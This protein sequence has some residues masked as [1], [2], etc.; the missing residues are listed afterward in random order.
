MGEVIKLG[1][2]K[3]V[4]S[5]VSRVLLGVGIVVSAWAQ[6]ET[7][8]Q[9]VD[10]AGELAS[11]RVVSAKAEDGRTTAVN[12]RPIDSRVGY[13]EIERDGIVVARS[14]TWTLPASEAETSGSLLISLADAM[15]PASDQGYWEFPTW[16]ELRH[17]DAVIFRGRPL[18]LAERSGPRTGASLSWEANVP[19][20]EWRTGASLDPEWRWSIAPDLL[21]RRDLPIGWPATIRLELNAS[22]P[23]GAGRWPLVTVDE[24]LGGDAVWL[25][26]DDVGEIRFELWRQGQAVSRSETLPW[27]EGLQVGEL[28]LG[29]FWP[30]EP[31]SAKAALTLIA[32]KRWRGRV[33][34]RW[35]GEWVWDAELPFL[36]F[37][38]PQLRWGRSWDVLAGSVR[39]LPGWGRIDHGSSVE[40]LL[41]VLAD[42]ESKIPLRGDG[43]GDWPGPLT[44]S[45]TIPSDAIGVVEP[46]LSTGVTGAGD[47]VIIK[48]EDAD[49]VRI[50]FD[51]WGA[52]GPWSDPIKID[53]SISQDITISMGN[54]WPPLDDPLYETH[55]EWRKMKGRVRI[56]LNGEL[57]LDG[58]YETHPIDASAVT[59]WANLIGGSSSIF[60]F[61][62][63]RINVRLAAPDEVID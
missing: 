60:R 53:P 26:R 48:Y 58:P 40:D 35:N 25:V 62:G 12:W 29:S 6:V 1:R 2:R 31:P 36:A 28:S 54:L 59:P 32:W 55:P 7:G 61:S 13:W 34:A 57:I 27:S 9:F 47:F 37:H 56:W 30:P 4:L 22:L 21:T 43:W 11:G 16:A 38:P 44:L 49:T 14:D 5:A 10:L 52:G 50:G 41:E 23:P 19:V 39:Y 8:P 20:R 15:P 46:L 63:R 18:V 45:F 3:R 33:W 24:R 51:H 17:F 42:Q